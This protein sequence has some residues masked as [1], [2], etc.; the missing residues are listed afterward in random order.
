MSKQTLKSPTSAGNK[1]GKSTGR[2]ATGTPKS[3]I[4]PRPQSTTYGKAPLSPSSK[5]TAKPK[6]GTTK[7]P[8]SGAAW[9][10]T[11]RGSQPTT[12]ANRPIRRGCLS[13]LL[14]LLLL[15]LGLMASRPWRGR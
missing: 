6:A 9:N 11:A 8:L 15:A 4:G 12:Y 14:P 7:Q 1:T 13:S 5:S 10:K 3:T 2:P